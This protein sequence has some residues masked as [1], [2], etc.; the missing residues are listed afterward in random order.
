MA[1]LFEKSNEGGIG[2]LKREICCSCG[3]TLNPGGHHGYYLLLQNRFHKELF[4]LF[5]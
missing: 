5:C 1:G 3:G 4:M 2:K